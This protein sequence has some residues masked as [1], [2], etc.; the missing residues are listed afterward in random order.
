MYYCATLLN[1][2]YFV[3]L[4]FI[5]PKWYCIME[6][7]LIFNRMYIKKNALNRS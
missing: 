1:S 7:Y 2:I 5:E 4:L 6:K 3:L